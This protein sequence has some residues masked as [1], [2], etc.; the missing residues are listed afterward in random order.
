[1]ITRIELV[2]CGS[3]GVGPEVMDELKHFNFVYGP[4]GAGKT[5]IS[6]L[7]ANAQVAPNSSLAWK[8]D[9]KLETLV[10]NR[11]FVDLNFNQTASLKGIFTLGEKDIE[12]QAKIAQAKLEAADL[13]KQRIKWTETLTGANANGGTMAELATEETSFTKRCWEAKTKFDVRFKDAFQGHRGDAKSFMAKVLSE[14]VSNGD[15]ELLTLFELESKAKTVFGPTQATEAVLPSFEEAPIQKLELHA[16]L[17]KKVFGKTDVDIAGMI[18]KLGNSDWVKSGIP[19]YNANNQLCPFCQQLTPETL[20]VSFAEYFDEVFEADTATIRMLLAD[21]KREAQ[22]IRAVLDATLSSGS[23]FLNVDTLKAEK[24]VF[25]AK[26]SLNVQLLEGK[27]REPSQTVTLDSLT[28]ALQ[29]LKKT[30]SSANQEATEHNALIKNRTQ[31]RALLTKQ[32]WKFLLDEE[33]KTDLVAYTKKKANLEL[34]I[35]GLKTKISAKQKEEAEKA[36]EIANLEKTATSVIPTIHAI[37][38]LL[39]TFGFDNF[40][41]GSSDCGKFY[42]ICRP[43]G[44]NAKDTLSEGEKSFVTFLYFFHLLK[45]SESSSGQTTDRVIVF[46]D[47]VSSMDSDVLFIVG[48]LIKGLFEEIRSGNHHIKQ[49]FV[50]THNVYFHKEITYEG[51]KKHP[52]T[53]TY[54]TV[55]KSGLLSKIKRHEK[56]PITTSYEMLWREVRSPNPDSPGLPNI[57]RRILENY[58]KVLGGVDLDGLCGYFSGKDK[59]VCKSLAAWAHDGSHMV[60]DDVFFAGD[61]TMGA[62]YLSVFRKIFELT[63]HAGHYKM[64]MAEAYT[65]P[66]ADLTNVIS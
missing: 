35:S 30:I 9:A 49:V 57:L 56:N 60:H 44:T 31:E 17:S 66:A 63:Q 58:F 24:D 45:G 48:S 64:M 25:E 43:D 51:V 8:N 46:D 39:K 20:S 2:S 12:V 29:A 1:M 41:V 32:V 23:K 34:A 59:I 61:G 3:Y 40:S 54:W 15:T 7:I 42:T 11:D 53:R 50:L 28:E 55:Y 21:Y 52:A 38:G 19:F 10:Y 5:T 47:P 18:R 22:V 16:I 4:N 13:C 36:I 65:E 6:R 33:L 26:V 62:A 27:G 14:Q 37:N